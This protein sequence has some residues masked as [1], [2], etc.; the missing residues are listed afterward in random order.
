MEESELGSHA[1]VPLDAQVVQIHVREIPFDDL[2]AGLRDAQQ[3]VHDTTN[4]HQ[5]MQV[6]D[7]CD[8][9]PILLLLKHRAL[10]V[11]R[12]P[13][14]L[15]LPRAP[16]EN[17]LHMPFLDGASRFAKQ[18]AMGI[19]SLCWATIGHTAQDQSIQKQIQKR[20]H[21]FSSV[22]DTTPSPNR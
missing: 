2:K 17:I 18:R 14:P 15:S 10:A 13:P 3:I 5:L 7:A 22:T 20:K 9:H 16:Q 6:L 11:V 8:T 4:L 12:S 1:S 19:P 21:A